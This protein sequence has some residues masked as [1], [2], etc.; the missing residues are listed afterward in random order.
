MN[1]LLLF[2]QF[3]H[4]FEAICECESEHILCKDFVNSGS[5]RSLQKRNALDFAC[6]HCTEQYMYQKVCLLFKAF[7]QNLRFSSFQRLKE[8]NRS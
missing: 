8:R 1:I 2:Y 5:F 4:F 7:Q 3:R 6:L